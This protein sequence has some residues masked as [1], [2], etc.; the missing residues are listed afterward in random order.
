MYTARGREL[1]L[2]LGTAR[3][4]TIWSS[5]SQ[6][7]VTDRNNV[8]CR[9]G[10]ACTQTSDAAADAVPYEY[11]SAQSARRPAGYC[12]RFVHRL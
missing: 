8:P 11:F 7:A 4:Y 6:V 5:D 1:R 12:R 9:G 10:H 3:D 2:R